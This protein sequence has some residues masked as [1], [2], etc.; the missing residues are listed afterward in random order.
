[1]TTHDN[2]RLTA[3][4]CPVMAYSPNSFQDNVLQMSPWRVPLSPLNVEQAS[5]NRWPVCICGDFKSPPDGPVLK[6]C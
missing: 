6:L 4:C 1:M 3:S 2:K 5:L